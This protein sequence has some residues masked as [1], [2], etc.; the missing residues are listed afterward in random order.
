[1]NS[2]ETSKLSIQDLFNAS[3]PETEEQ[4]SQLHQH[5]NLAFETETPINGEV[6]LSELFT[7]NI[8][9]IGN[10]PILFY[11]PECTP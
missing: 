5:L 3:L 4:I 8:P 11:V 10:V 7:E 9:V 1:M 2:E 6:D